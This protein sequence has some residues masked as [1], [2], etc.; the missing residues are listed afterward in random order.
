MDYPIRNVTFGGFDR[1]DVVRYLENFSRSAEEEKQALREEN[2]RLCAR[3]EKLEEENE[4][5][6]AQ[7][8]EARAQAAGAREELERETARRE[9]LES[10]REL[11]GEN[12]RL[13]S[14][15]ASL[16]RDA[17]AY[18]RFRERVGSIECE[19][20][21]RADALEA[22]ASEKMRRTMVQFQ[23]RYQELIRV[24]ESTAGHVTGELRKVEDNLSQLPRAMDQADREFDDLSDQISRGGYAPEGIYM[25]TDTKDMPEAAGEPAF[26][27][28]D[29]PEYPELDGLA[30][31][32]AAQPSKE[33]AVLEVP[34]EEPEVRQD[35]DGR[36][37]SLREA[38]IAAAE[39]KAPDTGR[40]VR[41][42][43]QSRN[44]S[45]LF[46]F[47]ARRRPENRR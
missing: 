19:A 45:G 22:G 4:S 29:E 3:T 21:E 18:A 23:E 33:P 11:E 43:V 42:A 9:E 28:T 47:G 39:A 31:D 1:Q 40:T 41:S 10:L 14:E 46:G 44:T 6:R 13:R 34:P 25:Y 12:I 38:V 5:L 7:L 16:R 8:E 15:A 30:V 26:T 17:A 36:V 2:D 35:T 37:N 20:R 24:I 27:N 32:E